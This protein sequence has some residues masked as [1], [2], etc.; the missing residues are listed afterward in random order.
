MPTDA[1]I[2]SLRSWRDNALVAPE[3][4][5]SFARLLDMGWTDALRETHPEQRNYTYWDYLH[6]AWTR[7][8]GMRLDHL[9]L[10]RNLRQRL[11]HANVDRTVRGLAGASDHA[12]AWIE[13][14]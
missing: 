9:L 4:R 10:S 13:L 11:A 1:D 2:Y 12:P 8:A 3:P 7:D 5:A 14:R 6:N